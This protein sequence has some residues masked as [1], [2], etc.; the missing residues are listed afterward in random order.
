MLVHGAVAKKVRVVT[1]LPVT[2]SHA[3]QYGSTY[4]VSDCPVCPRANDHAQHAMLMYKR[5]V[6]EGNK[7][8][9]DLTLLMY[10]IYL[11]LHSYIP[12]AKLQHIIG[13]CIFV[14]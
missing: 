7:C 1:W 10:A 3:V 12:S 14:I 13:L 2:I 5:T 11:I 8:C 6:K 4:N 9:M